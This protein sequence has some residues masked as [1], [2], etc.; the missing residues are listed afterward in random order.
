MPPLRRVHR[1]ASTVLPIVFLLSACCVALG[2][3][4]V[5]AWP[6]V[7]TV[8][9]TYSCRKGTAPCGSD[10]WLADERVCEHDVGSTTACSCATCKSHCRESNTPDDLTDNNTFTK[11]SAAYDL[12]DGIF[13]TGQC[14]FPHA[15]TDYGCG[16]R[17]G[18]S[19]YVASTNCDCRGIGTKDEGCGCGVTCP[20]P[21]PPLS[22]PPPPSPPLSS[23]PPIVVSPPPPARPTS[24]DRIL[25]ATATLIGYDA[26]SFNVAAKLLAFR[27]GIASVIQNVNPDAI[28]IISVSDVNA[29]RRRRRQLLVASSSPAVDVEYVVYVYDES[30]TSLTSISNALLGAS[31]VDALRA[32]GLNDLTSVTVMVSGLV[33]PPPPPGAPPATGYPPIDETLNTAATGKPNFNGARLAG[34][35]SGIAC[36]LIATVLYQYRAQIKTWYMKDRAG[37][38]PPIQAQPPVYIASKSQ[39][40]VAVARGT[41]YVD[42]PE[43]AADEFVRRAA[44]NYDVADKV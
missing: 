29:K 5:A 32:Q 38:K 42:A 22:S 37:A 6:T 43:S 10:G 34:L 11:P 40:G 31:L 4:R 24:L 7:D 33:V 16:C 25:N 3:V 35:L 36:F 8:Q 23:P 20:S 30:S 2:S 28:E 41:I 13:C 17:V 12:N 39:V 15:H 44:G 26:A 19:T 14:I 1:D 9:E 18:N 27:T 21:P